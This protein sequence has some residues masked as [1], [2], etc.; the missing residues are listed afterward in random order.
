MP[1]IEL[2]ILPETIVRGLVHIQAVG[3]AHFEHLRSNTADNSAHIQA[4]GVII[5]TMQPNDG[6]DDLVELAMTHESQ[7]T[8]PKSHYPNQCQTQATALRSL[9]KMAEILNV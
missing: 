9:P 5:P 3:S 2:I 8:V 1:D 7:K 4:S 6:M